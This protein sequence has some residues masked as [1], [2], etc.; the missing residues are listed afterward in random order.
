MDIV[1]DV[2]EAERQA[3]KDIENKRLFFEGKLVS[4][5]ELLSKKADDMLLAAK[6]ESEVELSKLDSSLEIDFSKKRT[7]LDK[8]L[9]KYEGVSDIKIR[10]VAKKILKE[11]ESA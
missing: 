3:L 9:S 1:V 8:K 7:L 10:A 6:K 11:I 4:E 5:K 2:I